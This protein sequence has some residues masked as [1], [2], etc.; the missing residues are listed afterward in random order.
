MLIFLFM[1]IHMFKI[2]LCHQQWYDVIHSLKNTVC[3]CEKEK[4][5]KIII[6]N[7]LKEKK[8]KKKLYYSIL[9]V[10]NINLN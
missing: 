10:Y 1:Y 3:E 8:R 9:V 7:N 2:N 5:K 4:K 6:N